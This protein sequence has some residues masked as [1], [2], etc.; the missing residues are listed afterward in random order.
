MAKVEMTYKQL[1][2]M[3]NEINEYTQNS[4][5][6]QLFFQEKIEKFRKRNAIR[7]GVMDEKLKQLR[8]DCVKHSDDGKPVILEDLGQGIV[9]YDFINEEKKKEYHEA[10]HEFMNRTITVE[11]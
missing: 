4:I 11:F 6:W 2:R 5:T 9:K 1:L 3:R 10:Y 7:L 8:L